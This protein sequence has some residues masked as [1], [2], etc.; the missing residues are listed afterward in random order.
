MLD[1]D[2][3]WRM[4]QEQSS[5]ALRLKRIFDLGNKLSSTTQCKYDTSTMSPFGVVRRWVC[6][7]VGS[8]SQTT[9]D[10]DRH[11]RRLFLLALFPFQRPPQSSVDAP[12][13][14]DFEEATAIPHRD[15]GLNAISLEGF[16]PIVSPT[17]RHVE[18]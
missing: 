18:R 3:T 13:R 9:P 11:G 1:L 2:A 4:E 5:K 10:K 14:H 7:G 6:I 17:S 12:P 15:I 16:I 8:A